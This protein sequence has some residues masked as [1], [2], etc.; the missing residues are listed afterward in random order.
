MD[1]A[2]FHPYAVLADRVPAVP[3]PASAPKTARST[4]AGSPDRL[5]TLCHAVTVS[6][7]AVESD[8]STRFRASIIHRED[9]EFLGPEA[10]N[11]GY[12]YPSGG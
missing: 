11:R 10:R 8:A 12:S 1:K 9:V 7:S 2:A 3:D 4:G 5:H 6:R